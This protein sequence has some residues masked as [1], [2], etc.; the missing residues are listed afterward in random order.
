MA[1]DNFPGLPD[2][3]QPLAEVP[4][5]TLR[6]LIGRTALA[7]SGEESRY[8]LNGALLVLKPGKVEMVATE[9]VRLSMSP[10]ERRFASLSL[11]IPRIILATPLHDAVTA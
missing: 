7:M 1:K 10:G 2:V 9:P 11:R 3:L 6:G 8:T 4:A 5:G